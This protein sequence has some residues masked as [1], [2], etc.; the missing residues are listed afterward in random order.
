MPII[1][2]SMVHSIFS[3]ALNSSTNLMIN[4]SMLTA[5]STGAKSLFLNNLYK[6]L[7]FIKKCVYI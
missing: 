5:K 6:K 7:A 4:S 1:D 2:D 3:L